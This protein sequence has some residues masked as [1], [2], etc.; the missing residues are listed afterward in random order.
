MRCV[1][2]QTPARAAQ[3][4]AALLLVLLLLSCRARALAEEGIMR[5]EQGKETSALELFDRALRSNPEEPLALYGKGMLLSEEQITREIALAMLRQATQNSKL[6]E[7]YRVLG[8]LRLA[9]IFAERKLRDDAMQSL[10]NLTEAQRLI[11]GKIARR[12]A[13]IYLKLNEKDRAREVLTAYLEGHSDDVETEYALLKLYAVT[14]KD[15]KSANKLCRKA[16]WQKNLNDKYL[17]N[18][19]RISAALNDY[20]AALALVELYLKRVKAAPPKEAHDLRDAINR[21]RGKFEL[22]EADF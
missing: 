1:R 9:E 14:L 6:P 17:L 16:D 7:K 13:E 21:K 5:M 20:T 3:F 15:L 10:A 19:A 22:T 8:Y 18:C 2:K 11:N 12:Q 4:L